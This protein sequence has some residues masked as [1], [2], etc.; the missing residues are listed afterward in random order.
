MPA[1]SLLL[2]V[3]SGS[4]THGL[5]HF[6]VIEA[7]EC[8]RHER[9]VCDELLTDAGMSNAVLRCQTVECVLT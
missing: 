8:W 7:P 9:P 3:M 5:G 6:A 4:R 2:T 1:A